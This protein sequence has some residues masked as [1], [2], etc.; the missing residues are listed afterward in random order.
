MGGTV[1]FLGAL[2]LFLTGQVKGDCGI[3]SEEMSDISG[4][5]KLKCKYGFLRSLD[6][7]VSSS[8]VILDK[9]R[10]QC[11]SP[12]CCNVKLRKLIRDNNISHDGLLDYEKKTKVGYPVDSDVIFRCNNGGHKIISATAT[13]D[14]FEID[15]SGWNLHQAA[16]DG[17]LCQPCEAGTYLP[18]ERATECTSCQEGSFSNTVGATQCQ[19]CPAGS[20]SDDKGATSCKR[21]Q[22]GRFSED[23]GQTECQLCPLG[24]VSNA[25]G[26]T[27]CTSCQEGYFSDIEGGSRC[28]A[29]FEGE[30][31]DV[32]G[33]SQCQLC[34]AG[35]FSDDEGATS[36]KPCPVGYFSET[37]G[38]SL[39][40]QCP[41]G[42]YSREG[43][44]SC[45]VCPSEVSPDE[46]LATQCDT[47]CPRGKYRES[48]AGE[49]LYCPAGHTTYS[50]EPNVCVGPQLYG[51]DMRRE[52]TLLTAK[53]GYDDIGSPKT[54]FWRSLGDWYLFRNG[55]RFARITQKYTTSYS[56][57]E[58]EI[59]KTHA[60]AAEP[61]IRDV[62][63]Y[64]DQGNSY[65]GYE[66]KTKSGEE[67]STK[68]DYCTVANRK[69]VCYCR[70]TNKSG[71]TKPYCKKSNGE[72]EECDVPKCKAEDEMGRKCRYQKYSLKRPIGF[73]YYHTDFTDFN[74]AQIVCDKL[75][76]ECK[77]VWGKGK[78]WRL[79]EQSV[80]EEELGSG[81][82][83]FYK[84]PSN[85]ANPYYEYYFE[86]EWES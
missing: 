65:R 62:Y 16:E 78:S 60:T 7:S 85:C 34:P 79:T 72:L 37:E 24:K 38:E 4:P 22:V 11:F 33:A 77:G 46:E 21:C 82:Y 80:S 5:I 26:A 30:Y 53:V 19:L 64:T 49:C 76:G 58:R 39:C 74:S 51:R 9:D 47:R 25:E 10:S 35:T 44:D 84:K 13:C 6:F 54:F 3:A 32:P 52:N 81:D 12:S 36:C 40:E 15:G 56:K 59:K 23:V 28:Q 29:C 50:Y 86:Q 67:C 73:Q 71:H 27:R 48:E 14:R 75:G 69:E 43:A 20:F 2:T 45:E 83:E 42:H 66:H 8:S 31:S 61:I 41:A 18:N 17:T 70:N 63:C 57:W 55:R 1:F 68:S